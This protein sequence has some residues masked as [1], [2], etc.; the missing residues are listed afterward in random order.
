MNNISERLQ[1]LR[2]LHNLKQQDVADATGIA[3]GNISKY[4]NGV[5]NPSAETLI[6][7]SKFFN[8]S[9]DWILIGEG[10]G[11]EEPC[12]EKGYIEA[13][14]G[15]GKSFVLKNL[16]NELFKNYVKEYISN[17]ISAELHQDELEE[18]VIYLADRIAKIAKFEIDD[19]ITVHKESPNY[20]VYDDFKNED[21]DNPVYKVEDDDP[22][23]TPS[24]D[25]QI[26][27]KLNKLPAYDI[28]ELEMLINFKAERKLKQLR[29]K[30]VHAGEE[31]AAYDAT[32]SQKRIPVL[33]HVAAGTPIWAD[34]EY[35]DL[36]PVPA[37]NTKIDYALIVRGDSMEPEFKDGSILFARKQTTLENG[38][39]GIILVDDS[40]TCKVLYKYSDRIELHSLNKKYDPI[41]IKGTDQAMITILGKVLKVSESQ[42]GGSF[43]INARL[44]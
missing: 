26:I 18:K 4:E 1:Y 11:P 10:K 22:V 20:K 32:F 34:S 9:T 5:V 37:N 3:R 35:I 14:W 36:I 21:N 40:A 41:V 44:A 31:A 19:A 23:A 42:N 8:V 15:T 24:K 27:N 33:G 12:D 6:A 7:Y 43:V 29:N 25:W 38:E 30:A 16:Y 39:I 28:E 17:N 13:S 2:D